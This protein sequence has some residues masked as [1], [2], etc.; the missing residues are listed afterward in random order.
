M[1]LPSPLENHA[2]RTCC[3]GASGNRVPAGARL[4]GDGAF[5]EPSWCVVSDIQS[6]L[7][8]SM[9]HL[10]ASKQTTWCLVQFTTFIILHT[11]SCGSVNTPLRAFVL[12]HCASVGLGKRRIVPS[13]RQF[14]IGKQGFVCLELEAFTAQV[15]SILT[16]Y[17]PRRCFWS[18]GQYFWPTNC[19]A[20]GVGAV[21]SFW[22]TI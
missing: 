1:T 10:R 22:A 8:R 16:K 9:Q 14:R 11:A 3:G 2:F 12:R 13:F 17:V 21:H 4:R 15:W 7:Q 20:G 19:Y 18:R 6:Y 5:A